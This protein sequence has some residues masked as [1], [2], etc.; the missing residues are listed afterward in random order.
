MEHERR[1]TGIVRGHGKRGRS[2]DIASV[3]FLRDFPKQLG[4]RHVRIDSLKPY[5]P[6]VDDICNIIEDYFEH[7]PD[8]GSI[9]YD[10]LTEAIVDACEIIIL[11][12]SSDE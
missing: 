5:E 7:L 4:L 12:E 10:V 1:G 6:P 8:R 11:K 3:A 2:E 9:D